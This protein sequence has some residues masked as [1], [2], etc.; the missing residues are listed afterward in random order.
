M[1]TSCEHGSWKHK[2]PN[3]GPLAEGEEWTSCQFYE[4]ITTLYKKLYYLSGRSCAE[5]STRRTFFLALWELFRLFPSK[6]W[7]GLDKLHDFCI[8]YICNSHHDINNTMALFWPP[9]WHACQAAGAEKTAPEV[10][11]LQRHRRAFQ[12]QLWFLQNN[13]DRGHAADM[14]LE[15]ICLAKCDNCQA[16]DRR[17]GSCLMQ[18]LLFQRLRKKSLVEVL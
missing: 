2:E 10:K 11:R 13:P 5:V 9:H 4:V 8:R 12:V 15:W 7:N 17:S 14:K 3:F 1:Y 16:K 18:Q 6:H